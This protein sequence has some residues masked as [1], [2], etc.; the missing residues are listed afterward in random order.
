[1]IEPGQSRNSIPDAVIC[2]RGGVRWDA[3]DDIS[4]PPEAFARLV[5]H[6]FPGRKYGIWS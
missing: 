3:M 5:P 1:M 2:F 6:L 4:Q